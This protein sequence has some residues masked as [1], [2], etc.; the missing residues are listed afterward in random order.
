[1]HQH[2]IPGT[3]YLIRASSR[4]R[5]ARFGLRTGFL[6]FQDTTNK[7]LQPIQECRTAQRPAGTPM[8]TQV[9]KLFFRDRA[10]QEG[11]PIP[12]HRQKRRDRDQAVVA[13]FQVRLGAAPRPLVRTLHKLRPHGIQFHVT[14]R[15]QQV[16]LVDDER[17]EP[18]LPEIAPPL[19]AEVDT[20]RAG[21]DALRR[22]R[23]ASR[24]RFAAPR[25][26]VR[27]SA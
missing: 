22:G 6:R 21:A 7:T 3:Q 15:C 17:S 18:P 20:P 4:S 2:R 16:R 24:P 25:S 13:P 14:R 8:G 1:M 23:A 11:F 26:G 27:G 10:S 12:H 5:S 19:L 9:T